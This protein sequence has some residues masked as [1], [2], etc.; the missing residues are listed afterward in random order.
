MSKILL[1][2]YCLIFIV[3]AYADNLGRLFTSP[4]DRA[5]LERLRHLKP[6][7][8]KKIEIVKLEEVIEP[9]IEEKEPL[10]QDPIA[11]KGLVHR[12]DGKNFAWINDSNTYDGNLESEFIEVPNDQITPDDVTIVMPDDTTKVRIKVGDYYAPQSNE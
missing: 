1:F 12:S 7:E 4:T 6:E 8:P 5:K 10:I 9:V 3:P 11:L 2:L